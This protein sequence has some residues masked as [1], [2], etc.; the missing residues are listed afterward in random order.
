MIRTLDGGATWT[1][2]DMSPHASILI[3]CY[4]RN[5][6]HGWVVG[7]KADEPT[8]TTR[9]RLKPVVLETT[10]GGNTWTNRLD[11]QEDE[12]LFGEWGWKVQFLDEHVGFVSL[13]NFAAAAILKTEDGGLSW[14][15]LPVNDPQGNVNLEGIG[16]IDA[17]RG[18]VGGWG[19]G[20]FGSGG[21]PQGFSS[22]TS[23]GGQ[24]WTDANEIGLYINRF[25]FFGQPVTIGYA[26]GDTVYKYTS[27]PLPAVAAL[28]PHGNAERAL[29]PNVQITG[30]VDS[31]PIRMHIPE[32][33]KRL[34]LL[35]WDRF[36]QE[37]GTI[38]DEI[39]P[40]PGPRN[41]RWD[42]TDGK[43]QAVSPGDYLLRMIADDLTVSSRVKLLEPPEKKKAARAAAA[44]PRPRFQTLTELVAAPVHDLNWLREALQVA[45]E[46][47]LA[48]LPPYLTARWTI[49]SPGDAVSRTIKQ[50]AREEMLHLGLA[51][52][53][54]TAIGG[55]PVIADEAVVPKYPGPLPWG[56]RPGLIVSLRLLDRD[57]A[58]AFMEIE[59][60]QHDPL[61]FAGGA[62]PATIGE[63]YTAILE[64]FRALDP[65]LS[66]EHQLQG[67]LDLFVIDTLAAVEQAIWLI[68]VQGEGSTTSPEESPGMLAHYYEFGEIFHGRRLIK[69]G[70]RYEYAGPEVPLPDVYNMA[71]VPEGGYQRP[72][73]PDM[74]VWDMVERFDRT[75]S[76]LLRLLEQAWAQGDSALLW[77]SLETMGTLQMTGR[78][79]IATPRPDSQENYGPSF[80]YVASN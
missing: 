44:A 16:F 76:E 15:R 62:G 33:T 72:D 19:P 73:V 59:R 61:A 68:S 7:G 24:T 52:N 77:A 29:L 55:T 54:L 26:S 53:L 12:F 25:R 75:Y 20:G 32:G 21:D 40:A 31:V 51:C 46:L 36:G 6:L 14:T 69:V 34:S 22:G 4:F 79:L 47:E 23:D 11:G 65:P 71:D 5:P 78:D 18:W 43:G 13:E 49:K 3:D 74:A 9:D 28:A 64:A 35:A 30:P 38:L 45:V 56:I 58:H 80:R 66:V 8:P 1:A 67:P 42:G 70:N 57:Q 27:D 37:L 60:P 2:W 41:W 39:R 63:F 50:I 17:R 10:D 48:T